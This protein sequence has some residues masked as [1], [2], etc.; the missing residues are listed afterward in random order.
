LRYQTKNTEAQQVMYLCS[1]DSGISNDVISENGTQAG[2]I[3]QDI[4]RPAKGCRTRSNYRAD[5]MEPLYKIHECAAN[6]GATPVLLFDDLNS[7]MS[8][9]DLMMGIRFEYDGTHYR[10]L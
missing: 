3:V 6:E 9:L 10:Y 5:D 2:T 4:Y 8:R 7:V 1:H